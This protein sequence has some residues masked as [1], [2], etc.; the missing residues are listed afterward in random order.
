MKPMV[1]LCQTLSTIKVEVS[2][3]HNRSKPYLRA[4]RSVQSLLKPLS[5]ATKEPM[6]QLWVTGLPSETSGKED[7]QRGH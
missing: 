4:E 7:T 5:R 6:K 3:S 1:N 2:R